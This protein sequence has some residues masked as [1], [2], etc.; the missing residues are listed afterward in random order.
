M[1]MSRGRC[2]GDGSLDT[3]MLMGGVKSYG[4]NGLYIEKEK[5]HE[6]K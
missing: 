4:I 3:L 2:Q 1:K 5:A 6:E